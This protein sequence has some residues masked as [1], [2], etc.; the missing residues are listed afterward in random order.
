MVQSNP[1]FV[2]VEKAMDWNGEVVR[3]RRVGAFSK[4]TDAERCINEL[5]RPRGEDCYYIY[6]IELQPVTEVFPGPG[7]S[8][9]KA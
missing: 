1:S 5:N 2:V 8:I 6:S 4:R 3:T 9:D 7:T